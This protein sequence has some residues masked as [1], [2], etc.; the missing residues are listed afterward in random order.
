MDIKKQSKTEILVKLKAS[1]EMQRLQKRLTKFNPFRILKIENFEIRHSNILAWLLDPKENHGLKDTVLRNIINKVYE[2][3]DGGSPIDVQ[4]GQLGGVEI[5]REWGSY[6]SVFR[7]Q[8]QGEIDGEDNNQVQNRRSL[9]LLVVIK[10]PQKIVIV[11]ENKIRATES[12]GQLADYLSNVKRE[13]AGY[14]IC[15]VFLTLKGDEPSVSDYYTFSWAE[16]YQIL[17]TIDYN[18]IEPEVV[19]FI[20]CYTE[21]LG[22][23]LMVDNEINNLCKQICEEY[24]DAID[25]INKYR[26]QTKFSEA[27]T[28]FSEQINLIPSEIQTMGSDRAF[29]FVPKSFKGV[30]PQIKC[31]QSDF[32]FS[33]FFQADKD[34]KHLYLRGEVS[35]INWH[36]LRKE[37]MTDLQS[38]GKFRTININ[39]KYPR[40]VEEKIS[41]NEWD[42]PNEIYAAMKS[43]Y[44]RVEEKNQYIISIVGQWYEKN[45]QELNKIECVM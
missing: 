8:N 37:L 4:Y 35:E 21:I 14:D 20:G 5:I 10:K 45:T 3:I 7:G 44:H 24:K 33:Y 22:E 38:S 40:F 32:V 30:I 36:D 28:L 1:L 31:W 17:V 41:I 39:S 42:N 6:C 19:H 12:E 29:W 15:P 23:M 34:K 13:Y 18:T 26:G 11:I 16:I 25:Y 27:V 9:D 2:K 43:L